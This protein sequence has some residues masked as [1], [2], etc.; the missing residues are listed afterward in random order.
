[1]QQPLD[2]GEM[3]GASTISVLYQRHAPGIFSYLHLHVPSREDAEDLLVET[4]LAACESR[5]FDTLSEERQRLWLWRV[6]RNKVAD[7]YRS[8]AHRPTINVDDLAD[9]IYTDE[10]CAPELLAERGEE[11]LQLRKGVQQLPWLQ[12]RILQLRFVNDL[13]SAEI[14]KA[15]GKS[16]TAVRMMLS[17]TL[18]LL[19][20]IYLKK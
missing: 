17:R 4:F 15:V 20:S 14:A 18:N 6:V 16:D 19:R 11:Y 10:A 1:M 9:V 8:P 2:L 7:Y 12:Q 3:E 13:T 5:S